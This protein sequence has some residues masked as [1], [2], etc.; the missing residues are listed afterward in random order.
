MSSKAV[1][2]S[3]ELSPELN[4]TLEDLAARTG[5]GTKADVLRK[6]IAVLE[7]AIRAKEQGRRFG[8]AQPDQELATEIIGI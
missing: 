6:A 5:N 3:L 1:R 2:L 4:A 7:I 8:I